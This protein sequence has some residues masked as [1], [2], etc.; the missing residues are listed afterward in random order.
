MRQTR[1][2]VGVRTPF[3]KQN[4][5]AWSRWRPR[6]AAWIC[7]A[8]L[9]GPGCSAELSSTVERLPADGISG[10]RVFF[11]PAWTDAR[12]QSLTTH[13]TLDALEVLERRERGRDLEILF[14]S[15][16]APGRVVFQT[17]DG[18]QLAIEFYAA[19]TDGD[20]DGF[21][22]S[23]E[24]ISA[25]DRRAFAEWFVRIAEAQYIRPSRAWNEREQDCAGLIRFAYREALKK[26]DA[27]WQERTGVLIDK[28]LP[29]AARFRYP[30]IPYL[31][32]RIFRLRSPGARFALT[33][34]GV[35]ADAATLMQWN[36]RLVTREA[37][38]AQSGD[39]LFFRS[40]WNL[41][42]PY[43]SMIVAGRDAQGL[44][45][46]YHTGGAGGLKRAP[47]AYLYASADPRWRPLAS[48]PHFLGVFRLHI[49]D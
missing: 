3:V 32:E 23:S 14:K 17:Q 21:P 2:N 15:T 24:L 18:L 19:P 43:H 42:F 31:G 8:V 44:R 7:L 20:N 39:L 4:P 6:F 34:F 38:Q 27:A 12:T 35:F 49:L 16:G 33:D 5:S 48:N 37:D 11:S 29:D 25:E 36:A 45:V 10:G 28:N 13:G 9:A 46:I 26:H 40:D 41:E 1:R 30:R 47:L 22:D